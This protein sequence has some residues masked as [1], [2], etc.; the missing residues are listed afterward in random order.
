MQ[1]NANVEELD[2]DI[3]TIIPLGLII[4]ELVSNSFKHAF[5]NDNYGMILLSISLNKS[6]ELVLEIKDDGIGIVTQDPDNPNDSFGMKLIESLSKKL[7]GTIHFGF[8]AG[9]RITIIFT[10]FK[11]NSKT[12]DRQAHP[13]N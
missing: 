3:D 9:T 7:N 4:N 8:E 6:N 12:D 1:L 5:P 13:G 11:L 10:K 2:L